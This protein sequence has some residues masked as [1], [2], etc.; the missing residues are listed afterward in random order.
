MHI[1]Q[2]FLLRIVHDHDR[3]AELDVF[4]AGS[5]HPHVV[6]GIAVE[7]ETVVGVLAVEPK[8]HRLGEVPD[9]DRSAAGRT[10]SDEYGPEVGVFAIIQPAD[11]FP[12]LALGIVIAVGDR[13]R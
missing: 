3:G 2:K 12:V 1:S 4:G 6:V 8:L 10:M 11:A 5:V 13:L 7:K 9:A